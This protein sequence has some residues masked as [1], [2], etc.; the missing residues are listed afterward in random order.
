MRIILCTIL[1]IVFM[2]CFG[3]SPF[4]QAATPT[5]IAVVTGP[6]IKVGLVLDDANLRAGPGTNTK[7]IG[8]AKTGQ[9]ITIVATNEQGDWYQLDGGQWIAAFLVKVSSTADAVPTATATIP[10]TKLNVRNDPAFQAYSKELLKAIDHF[11]AG[12]DI[13][14][15]RFT[16]ASTSL[17]VIFTDNW[18]KDTAQALIELKL[19]NNAV[20][21]LTPPVYLADAHNDLLKAA[22]HIDKM[23]ALLPES[24]DKLDPDK[25]K[26]SVTEYQTAVRLID[27]SKKK[28]VSLTSAN[29]PTSTP[30]L[31]TQSAGVLTS[32]LK[33]TST[34]IP[35]PTPKP[36]LTDEE[37]TYLHKALQQ[38]SDVGDAISNIGTLTMSPRIGDSAWIIQVGSQIAAV[39]L[40]YSELEELDSPAR[41]ISFHQKLLSG[42][43]QC[44]SAVDNLAFGID[45][46][47]VSALELAA[48]QMT[49][50]GE[51][52]GEASTFLQ[53]ILQD[54]GVQL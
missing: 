44:K 25:L 4:A 5:P 38:G 41:F 37:R 33:P 50:C 49:A 35:T 24:L 6:T 2:A 42:V 52:V 51:G 18:K 13:L 15:K 39:R 1:A 20:R 14:N 30:T 40:A 26:T 7:V 12:S 28:L 27:S 34:E 9:L 43:R 29:P 54:L 22:G 31:A 3:G 21:K 32:T 53:T 45:N 47:D 10:P 8:S 16:E 36:G 23:L 11:I 19:F 17:Y 48:T 46:A